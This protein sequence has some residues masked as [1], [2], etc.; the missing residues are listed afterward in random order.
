MDESLGTLLLCLFLLYWIFVKDPSSPP[1]KQLDKT[2]KTGI[3]IFTAVL[4]AW[5]TYKIYIAKNNGGLKTNFGLFKEQLHNGGAI[6]TINTQGGSMP[7][8]SPNLV[9]TVPVNSNF[10]APRVLNNRGFWSSG[11]TNTTPVSTNQTEITANA[12]G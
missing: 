11:T 1:E 10:G 12:S 5:T 8:Q 6:P 7:D 2:S 9:D 3:S 4:A